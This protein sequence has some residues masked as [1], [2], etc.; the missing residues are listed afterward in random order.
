M[1]L[2]KK[3]RELRK[4]SNFSQEEFA[5]KLGVARQTISKWENKQTTPD[6]I[7]A[8]KIARLF[9]ISLDELVG[10]EI[11][12]K[13]DV[14]IKIIKEE[15]EM[16]TYRITTRP[17]LLKEEQKDNVARF[18]TKI[19]MEVTGAPN[20]FAQMI[21]DESNSRRYIG[22][23]LSDSQIWIH[24]DI[25]AGKTVE[26]KETLIRK[27]I[28]GVSQIVEVPKSDIWVYLN[29]ME[30]T[31]MAEFGQILPKLGQEKEWFESLPK[32]LQKKLSSIKPIE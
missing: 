20:Y 30:A 12:P 15:Q 28:D 19:H 2:G 21:F 22:G 18:I 13:E 14:I 9:N 3:I 7:Q 25:R 23:E 1:R 8:Q 32:D 10:N 5:E 27:I 16:P 24:A 4:K 29:N 31:D 11:K 6:V 26:Q 17:N